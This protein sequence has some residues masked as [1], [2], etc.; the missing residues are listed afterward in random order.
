MSRDFRR[1]DYR[2]HEYRHPAAD[3]VSD[4]LETFF[5]IVLMTFGAV[6]V[7]FLVAIGLIVRALP[8]ILA[9][10]IVLWIIGVI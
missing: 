1:Y 3:L 2:R 7:V 5:A 8:M 9:C 4:L 10:L 6:V